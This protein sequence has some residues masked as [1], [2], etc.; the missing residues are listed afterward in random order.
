M[1]KTAIV[2]C[3][4]LTFTALCACTS[5]APTGSSANYEDVIIAARPAALNETDIYSVVT[6]PESN[7]Y[8][9]IFYPTSP[10]IETD[11]QR[12]AISAPGIITLAY[13]IAIIL[14]A[15]GKEQAVLDAVNDFVLENQIAQENYLHDQYNIALNAQV[16]VAKTGEVLL[17]MCEDAETVMQALEA[18]LAA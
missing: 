4:L 14:P 17:A 2:L 11:M 6:G 18:G 5:N 8:R 1:K 7:Q 15:E 10:F 9:F 13:G 12:Y 16:K 3:V